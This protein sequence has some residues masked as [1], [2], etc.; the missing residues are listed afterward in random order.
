[1]SPTIIWGLVK[2]VGPWILLA[3]VAAAIG[4]LVLDRNHLAKLNDAHLACLASVQGKPAA[5]PLDQVCEP[6]I[7]SAAEAAAAAAACDHALTT[8]D[9]FAASQACTGPTKRVIADRD[10]KASEVANLNQQLAGANADRDAAVSRA[11]ARAQAQ[12][13]GLT[14]AQSV[15]AAAPHDSDGLGVCDADCLRKLAGGTAP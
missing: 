10:S 3:L 4:L 2:T 13:Q 6:A 7:A 11:Q 9:S 12:A 5:K 15:L 8:G 14:H 1:M